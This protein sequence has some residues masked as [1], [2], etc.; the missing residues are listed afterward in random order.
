[1]RIN[2]KGVTMMLLVVT[3][4]LMIM[5]AFLAVYYSQN[6][7]PEARVASALSSL[8]SVKDTCHGM[9]LLYDSSKDE[10]YYFGKTIREGHTTDEVL[11]FAIRCGLTNAND[12]GERTYLIDPY[13]TKDEDKR[14]IKNLELSNINNVFIIDLDNDKYYIVDGVSRIDNSSYKSY[15]YEDIQDM[16]D[17]IKNYGNAY[18]N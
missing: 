17:L 3:I 9:Q 12:F 11:D 13:S 7:A 1:M 2:N 14:R 15:E 5:I 4:I 16:Y 6:I 8:K 18:S 10:Y